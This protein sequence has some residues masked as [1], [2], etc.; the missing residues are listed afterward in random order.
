MTVAKL[1]A[2]RI[3]GYRA[4]TRVWRHKIV[5]AAGYTAT[6]I[7]ECSEA[8]MMMS[9]WLAAT[10]LNESRYPRIPAEATRR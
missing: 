5:H 4:C 1:S 9:R 6:S 7:R 8:R 2:K 10:R 3:N